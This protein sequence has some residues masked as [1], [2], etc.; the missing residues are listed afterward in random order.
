MQDRYKQTIRE[1]TGRNV[2]AFLSQAHVEPD[3]T[4]E[5]F[6]VDGPLRGFGAIEITEP[7]LLSEN[8]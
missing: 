8:D 1:L 6:F 7:E 3:I 4:V 2:T 5:M